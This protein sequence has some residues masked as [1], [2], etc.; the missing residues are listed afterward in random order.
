MGPRGSIYF[1]QISI[2]PLPLLPHRSP[3]GMI[4]MGSLSIRCAVGKGGIGVK[5]REGD[6]RTPMGVFRLIEWRRR[7]E[8][9]TIFRPDC[10]SIRPDDGWCDDPVSNRY[11][12]PVVLPCKSSAEHLWRNDGLY[13]VVG[14]LDFNFRPR[15]LGRGSAIFFHLALPELN[16]T[17][18]CIAFSR[19]SLRKLQM[20]WR[21]KL[22][23]VIGE[24]SPRRRAPKMAEPIRTLV[25][26]SWIATGKSSLMPIESFSNPN[27]AASCLRRAK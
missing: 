18:G 9:W 20:L 6:G 17:A 10:L 3:L 24:C 4:A 21:A 14:I 12:K 11:N 23:V 16:P 27:A 1:S 5:R 19:P 15:I 13:D 22:Q 26:P 25:A 7:S 2:R 8:N